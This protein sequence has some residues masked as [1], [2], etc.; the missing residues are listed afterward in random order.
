M[1]LEAHEPDA[2]HAQRTRT[3]PLSHAPSA[4][5]GP[6]SRRILRGWSLMMMSRCPLQFLALP[7]T[8][9]ERP[10]PRSSIPSRGTPPRGCSRSTP[11]AGGGVSQLIPFFAE[12][13]SA[14]DRAL[15]A[16]GTRTRS[17]TRFA[18]SAKYSSF[19]AA[20]LSHTAGRRAASPGWRGAKVAQ[21]RRC[22]AHLAQSSRAAG[23]PCGAG[24]PPPQRG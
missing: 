4:R 2:A 8:P 1:L 6:R 19:C 14:S 12:I 18:W 24:T 21:A 5:P 3:M 9:P 11:S 10:P 17:D 23:R 15:H 13:L 22:C 20:S 7:A 16:Q